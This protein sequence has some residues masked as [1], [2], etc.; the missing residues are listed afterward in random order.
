MGSFD[1]SMNNDV[2]NALTATTPC[3]ASVQLIQ[4]S[5]MHRNVRRTGRPATCALLSVSSWSVIIQRHTR[6][7]ALLNCRQ[8]SSKCSLAYWVFSTS[9]FPSVARQLLFA[10]QC[11]RMSINLFHDLCYPHLFQLETK[12]F[13]ILC[14]VV[15]HAQRPL[16]ILLTY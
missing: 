12:L 1:P 4:Y 2:S 8:T 9:H 10:C 13:A 15:S 7:T 14:G 6:H 11:S 16:L 3:N 5:Y